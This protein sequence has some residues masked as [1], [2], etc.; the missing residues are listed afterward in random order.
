ML[1]IVLSISAFGANICV[2]IK[3]TA[4]VSRPNLLFPIATTLVS[5]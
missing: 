3:T 5:A 2:F 1:K 4:A